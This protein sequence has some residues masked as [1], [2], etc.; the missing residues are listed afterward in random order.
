MKWFVTVVVSDNA[1]RLCLR[2]NKIWKQ[3]NWEQKISQLKKS[4]VQM[5]ENVYFWNADW[6]IIS[7][8][9]KREMFRKLSV[10]EFLCF[11]N[12]IWLNKS[13]DKEQNKENTAKKLFD[14]IIYLSCTFVF[15]VVR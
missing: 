13:F 1:S 15:I 11:T 5:P 10:L 14:E 12:N 3:S 2:T 4:V 8:F 6:K 9:I 7:T